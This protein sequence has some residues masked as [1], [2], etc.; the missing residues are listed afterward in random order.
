MRAFPFPYGSVKSRIGILPVQAGCCVSSQ[1]SIARPEPSQ[2]ACW[3][4]C[5]DSDLYRP[6][7]Q[8]R[9]CTAR[10]G[11]SSF[12]PASLLRLLRNR[13]RLLGVRFSAGTGLLPRQSADPATSWR[14]NTSRHHVSGRTPSGCL[15]LQAT[16]RGV[17]CLNANRFS[18]GQ[19][20]EFTG[21]LPEN[22]SAATL[23]GLATE[24]PA[25]IA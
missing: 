19:S 12:H 23:T 13:P 6:C 5:L 9:D 15:L 7:S 4:C 16:L 24:G 11:A 25:N 2:R 8:G 10:T 22:D 17:V 3:G 1:R 18:S 14:S 21:L 20:P